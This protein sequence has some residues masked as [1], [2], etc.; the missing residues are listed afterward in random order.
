MFDFLR[1][2]ILFFQLRLFDRLNPEILLKIHC[3][4]KKKKLKIYLLLPT[5]LFGDDLFLA[6]FMLS[7]LR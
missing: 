3:I 4:N 1:F 5:C 7:Y 2:K 6:I